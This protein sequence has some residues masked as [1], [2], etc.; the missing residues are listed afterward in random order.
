MRVFSV[1]GGPPAE[2]LT[3]QFEEL[4]SLFGL[5][6]ED[7]EPPR[8][9][10]PFEPL[11]QVPLNGLFEEVLAV[12]PTSSSKSYLVEGYLPS[13]AFTSAIVLNRRRRAVFPT[14]PSRLGICV[15]NWT[16]LS[17]AQR[18]GGQTAPRCIAMSRC[19][20]HRCDLLLFKLLRRTASIFVIRF[21]KCIKSKAD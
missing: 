4:L 6:V 5:Y 12:A 10:L 21:S 8:G 15:Q 19:L 20:V 3:Q 7:A 14:L 2:N 9:A 13:A 1:F 18:V 17:S 16:H 11:H